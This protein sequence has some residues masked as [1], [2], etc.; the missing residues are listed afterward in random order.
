MA[1]ITTLTFF[2]FVN[3]SAKVWAFGQMQFAHAYLA[4]SPGLSFYK[5]MGTNKPPIIFLMIQK[6]TKSIKKNLLSSG[7]FL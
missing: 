5:L 1:S 3:L 6:F 2:R 4:K 7:P